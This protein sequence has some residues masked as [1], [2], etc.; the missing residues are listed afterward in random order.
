MPRYGEMLEF[1]ATL[2][3]CA[4]SR[5]GFGGRGSAGRL[6]N[7]TEGATVKTTGRILECD[8]SG[9]LGRVVDSLGNPIDGKGPI[10]TTRTAPIERV[11]PA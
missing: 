7:I 9:A 10:K 6:Q 4:Q 8:R 3:P 1:P 5:T 2:R 11:A